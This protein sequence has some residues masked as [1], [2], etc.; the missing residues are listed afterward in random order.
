M[1][2]ADDLIHFYPEK[3]N[4]PV[5]PSVSKEMAKTIIDKIRLA[6]APLILAG[7]GI[8]LGNAEDEFLKLVKKLQIPVVT[9]W[10]ANDTL[11]YENPHFAGMPGTVGTRAGNFVVQN[12]DLLLSLA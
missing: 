3:E 12:C 7:T 6:K 1:I 9:A 8:R 2:E 5:I 11:E 4:M 10:N